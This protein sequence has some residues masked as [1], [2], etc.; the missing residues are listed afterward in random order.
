MV[1]VPQLAGRVG[2]SGAVC[3]VLVRSTLWT[4]IFLKIFILVFNFGT[5]GAEVC[6]I[7]WA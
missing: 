6:A 4:Q 3:A 1:T 7:D 5:G 2:E